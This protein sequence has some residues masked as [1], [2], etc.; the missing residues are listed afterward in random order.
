MMAEF[1]NYID[2]HAYILLQKTWEQIYLAGLAI[3]IA[4]AIGVPLGLLVAHREKS[5]AIVLNVASVFQTIPSLALLVFLLPFL[6]IGMKPAI[7]T[8]S[9]YALLPVISNTVAG[10]VGVAPV[11]IEAADGLGFTRMQRL[12]VVELPLALPVMLAGVRTAVAMSIGIATLAAFVGAGGLG[13]F[14]YQG[15]SLNDN[16]LVMLGAIPAALLAI[17]VDIF[18]RQFEKVVSERRYKK[19]P[20][21]LIKRTLFFVTISLVCGGLLFFVML[22]VKKH[23]VVRIGSKNFTEQIILGEAVAQLIESKTNLKAERHFNLAGTMVAHNAMLK[24]EIDIYPEYTGTGYIFILGKRKIVSPTKTYHI[25]KKLYQKRFHITWLKS[26]GFENSGAIILRKKFALDNNIS[27]VTQLIP[28]ANN[29]VFGVYGAGLERPDGL[30]GLKRAYNLH[31]KSIKLMS[32]GIMYK[33]IASDDVDVVMGSTTDG[34]ILR[35]KLVILRDDKG[36]FPP[37]DAA[38]IVRDALLKKHPRLKSVLEK[39]SGRID[40]STMRE[41]NYRVDVKGQSPKKVAHDFL[42]MSKII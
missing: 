1:F 6:G 37:Y 19:W 31:F 11:M 27:T 10:I 40:T 30:P 15:L 18:I 2:A 4:L 39:L 23:S 17:V 8:L 36:L 32:P 3:L 9:I 7:I 29:M 25:V 34:R 33:A 20:K 14:I 5:K 41:L 16:R 13:D 21:K 38:L 12:W 22:P 42:K 24:N 35:Y 26:L 28:F